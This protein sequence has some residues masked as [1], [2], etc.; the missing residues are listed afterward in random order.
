MT[1]ARDFEIAELKK[2]LHESNQRCK[3]LQELCEALQELKDDLELYNTLKKERI[4]MS[5]AKGG[6]SRNA[7]IFVVGAGR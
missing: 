1:D 5:R 3:A 7:F 4:Q 6:C 2:Q